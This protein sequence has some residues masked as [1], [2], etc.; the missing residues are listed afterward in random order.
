MAC[1]TV[2][3]RC[4]AGLARSQFPDFMEESDDLPVTMLPI[5]AAPGAAVAVDHK[6]V[7][8]AEKRIP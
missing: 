1:Q 5:R 7:T 6:V 3:L 8:V 2:G 4:T